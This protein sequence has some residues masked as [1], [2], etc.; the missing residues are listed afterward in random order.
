MLRDERMGLRDGLGAVPGLQAPAIGID[1]RIEVGQI[2][3]DADAKLPDAVAL[4]KTSG[5]GHV[6]LQDVGAPTD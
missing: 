6:R 5:E 2:S 3:R 1:A 4:A